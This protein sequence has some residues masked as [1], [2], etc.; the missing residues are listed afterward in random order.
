MG[1]GEIDAVDGMV[2]TRVSA[3]MLAA[4]AN[5]TE[6]SIAT[7][8]NPLDA[9]TIPP[10]AGPTSREMSLLSALSE[11]ARS[12]SRSATRCGSRAPRAGVT[13]WAIADWTKAMR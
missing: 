8:A 5:E 10:R 3:A 7:P 12:N 13:N 1:I 2:A 6:S 4:T 9:T 11:F